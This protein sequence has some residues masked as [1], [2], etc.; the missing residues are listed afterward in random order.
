IFLGVVVGR[1]VRALQA[2]AWSVR[3]GLLA[4]SL[5]VHTVGIA[6]GVRV[7]QLLLRRMGVRQPFLPLARVRLLAALGRYIP[8]KIW[9]FVGAAHLGAGTGIPVAVTLT[10]LVVYTGFYLTGA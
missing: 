8:G 10:S 6:W 7:W 3:P 1:D 9:E 5:A 4:L 2:H